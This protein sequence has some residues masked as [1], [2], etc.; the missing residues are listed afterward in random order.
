MRYLP[1]TLRT[2]AENLAL[3]ELLLD[4]YGD[5]L[6]IWESPT[7][8]VVMGRS[9][10]VEVEVDTAACERLGVPILRRISGG[11]T[12]VCGSGCLMY[13]VTLDL[14]NRPH[15]QAVDNC[16]REVLQPIAEALRCHQASVHIAGTSDLAFSNAPGE[17]AVKFSG[18][19]LRV[20]RSR[21]LY[22]GTLLYDYDTQLISEL[23]RTPPR[24]PEYRVERSH[25]AFVS[26]LPIDRETLVQALM[27]AWPSDSPAASI[28]DEQQRR[29]AELV[30][31]KYATDRW[32]LSR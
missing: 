21:L 8:L 3:D 2:P 19:S 11:A 23:L 28:T 27:T 4:S 15:L 5:C 9:S 22:H 12:I 29:V 17:L 6:R 30:A 16:H 26:N 10:A 24:R 18:N 13:A 7:P 1:A 25:A 31:G 32:N 20:T 14:Q